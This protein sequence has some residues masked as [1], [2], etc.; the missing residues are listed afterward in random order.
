MV[1]ATVEGLTK[2]ALLVVA[3]GATFIVNIIEIIG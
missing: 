1:V 2:L 3:P